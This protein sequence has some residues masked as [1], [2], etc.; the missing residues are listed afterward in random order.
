MKTI[1]AYKIAVKVLQKEQRTRKGLAIYYRDYGAPEYKPDYDNWVKLNE[2]IE[3]IQELII[4]ETEYNEHIKHNG[5]KRDD[6]IN[7]ITSPDLPG[8]LRDLRIR[9]DVADSGGAG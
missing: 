5:G 2:A 8:D 3:V 1:Q 7:A 9:R 6:P 4:S